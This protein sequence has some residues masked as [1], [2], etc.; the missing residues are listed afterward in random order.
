MGSGRVSFN[1]GYVSG[2]HVSGFNYDGNGNVT[3]DNLSN[4]Y[5]YDAEG[6]PVTVNG[7]Q[8]T[9]DA[10][11]RAVEQNRSGAYTQIVYSP[12]GSK[13]AYMSGQTLQ[14]YI[15]PLAGGVQAVFNSAGVQYVRH[16]DWLGSSRLALNTSG[17]LYSGR[18]YAP[19]GETYAESG[20]VDRS[21]TG[22]TQDTA[23]GA[24][25]LYDF[26]F[27]QQA[28]SQGR[29]LAPDPAGLAAVDLANPQTWNRYAYVG[30]SPNSR[31]DPT[32]TCDLIAGGFT[33]T[34][35]TGST[36]MQQ[37]LASAT[38]ANLAFPFSG[39]GAA[40]SY[41]SS[42][43]GSSSA[44]VLRNAIIDTVAQSNGGPTNLRVFSGSAG[45][46]GQIW[47][48]LPTSV[49]NGIT[50][51]TYFSPGTT[52]TYGILNPPGLGAGLNIFNG[53]V[54]TFTGS[55]LGDNAITA[56]V[57]ISNATILPCGHDA[58]CEFGNQFTS[59]VKS[60]SSG[61]SNQQVF[62]RQHANGG[63]GAGPGGGGGW[64]YSYGGFFLNGTI[65]DG[66]SGFWIGFGAPLPGGPRFIK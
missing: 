26:Q 23:G 31:I 46:L 2:N 32:G 17:N 40:G 62:T 66:Y 34:P 14:K 7:I 13:F 52:D 6:R 16:A 15:V 41:L 60:A 37:A 58:N 29:W 11:G 4:A 33:Q 21:Y 45:L 53:A 18:A 56:S 28:S 48:T 42:A 63:G 65:E 54:S 57:G 10:F 25:G 12:T 36:G 9:F 19:Y 24:T 44:D 5:T 64:G 27:R 61:C 55:T 8:T 50:S 30:N 43:L 22:Q 47:G 51:I 49:R 39:Q 59:L 1:N 20:T 35:N 3:L 38:G